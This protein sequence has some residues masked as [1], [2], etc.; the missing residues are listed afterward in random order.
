MIPYLDVEYVFLIKKLMSESCRLLMF[1]KME[2][3]MHGST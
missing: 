3:A 1:H 2:S